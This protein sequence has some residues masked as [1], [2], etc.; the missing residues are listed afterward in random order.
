MRVALVHDDL[1]QWGGAER[2]LVAISE[3][4]PEAPIYTSLFNEENKFLR[5]SFKDKKVITSFMQKIPGWKNLYKALLPI[6]PLAFEKFDFTGYDLVISQT[7]RFAKA[8]ITKPETLH[9]CYCHTPP[10]FLWHFSKEKTAKLLTPLLTYLRYYDQVTAHRVDKWLAGSENAR[11][12]IN[13]IYR[14]DAKTLLP[15]IDTDQFKDYKSFD[16]GY[17]LIVARLNDYKKVD[18]AVKVFNKN[19]KKL[20]IIGKGP[21]FTEL[22]KEANTN[23][24]LLGHV[25]EEAKVMLLKGAK[26]LIVTAEEDFGLTPLEAQACGKPVI[27][28]KS[29][30]A[31]ETVIENKTGLFF[32]EQTENSLSQTIES[33]EKQSFKEEDCLKNALKF[34]K[35]RFQKDLKTI[36]DEYLNQAIV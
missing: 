30:G 16:G 9:V 19:K 8:I 1:V 7:T 17:Y 10:R 35:E 36:L 20:K 18:L 29:G 5:E 12:R 34:S 3:V 27:A 28:L 2:V 4:F 6:Y 13:K 24:E 21:K 32:D 11:N 23:V 14:S 26:A 25:S 31:L 33:F 15:F 22:A